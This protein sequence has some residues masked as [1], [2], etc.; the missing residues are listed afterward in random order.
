MN[1]EV[2]HYNQLPAYYKK[3]EAKKY[4]FHNELNIKISITQYESDLIRLTACLTE[5]REKATFSRK[6]TYLKTK[7]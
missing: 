4:G 1:I 5:I 7:I 6:K 3:T 2:N